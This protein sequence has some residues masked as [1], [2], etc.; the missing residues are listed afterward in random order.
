[1]SSQCNGSD[2]GGFVGDSDG[3]SGGGVGINVAE[4]VV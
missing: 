4:E 2:R 1:M 3:G